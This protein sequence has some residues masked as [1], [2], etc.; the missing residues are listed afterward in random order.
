MPGLTSTDQNSSKHWITLW[1]LQAKVQ[2]YLEHRKYV[3]IPNDKDG[4]E[5]NKLSRKEYLAREKRISTMIKMRKI[6]EVQMLIRKELEVKPWSNG[7]KAQVY[8]SV[9]C[10]FL[11]GWEL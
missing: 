8:Y 9:P 3:G 2:A 5:D 6:S 1:F 11:L 4:K 10:L 7:I